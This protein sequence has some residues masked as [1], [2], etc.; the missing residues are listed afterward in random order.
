MVMVDRSKTPKPQLFERLVAPNPSPMTLTG[1]NTYLVGTG[2]VAIVD[3]GPDLSGHIDATLAAARR[4]GRIAMLL[5][6]H[7]HPDHLP[8][9]RVLREQT[10]APLVAHPR[11]GGVDQPLE[12]DQRIALDGLSLRA[13]YTPG[14]T[15][16]HF[17]FLL[18]DHGLLF[19]GDLVLG[20]GTTVIGPPD[21]NLGH[22]MASLERLVRVHREGGNLRRILPGHGPLVSAP[23]EKLEEYIRHRRLREAQVLDA[24]RRG[25][26][27]VDYIVLDIYADVDPRLHGAAG[28]NVLAHLEVLEEQ[29]RVERRGE[30]WYPLVA[31]EGEGG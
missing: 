24:L 28:R 1:T 2:N 7:Y 18:E 12:D 3:P 13:L 16:D 11:I 30:T 29:G 22:Y 9:A 5:V 8:A 23:V 21:G 31:H 27:S 19:T 15:N 20:E 17:C 14:H 26:S 4:R 10:G 6:T 25:L